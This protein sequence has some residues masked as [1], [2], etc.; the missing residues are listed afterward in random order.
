[1]RLAAY[2]RIRW[3]QRQIAAR[4]I[5]FGGDGDGDHIGNVQAER[6]RCFETRVDGAA[7]LSVKIAQVG[8]AIGDGR[9]QSIEIVESVMVRDAAQPQQHR[10]AQ[11]D[12]EVS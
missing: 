4:S 9:G 1:M 11:L 5:E 10:H 2:D 6:A 8:G 7:M 12:R 3:R